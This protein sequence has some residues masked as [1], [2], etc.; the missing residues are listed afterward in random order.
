MLSVE[1]FLIVIAISALTEAE[2][3]SLFEKLNHLHVGS[4]H[5]KFT[6]M[7]H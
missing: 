2:V 4:G 5:Q 6:A 3:F 1:R 7:G